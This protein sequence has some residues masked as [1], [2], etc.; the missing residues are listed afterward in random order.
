MFKCERRGRGRGK[1]TI[2]MRGGERTTEKLK[3][4][5]VIFHWRQNRRDRDACLFKGY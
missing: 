3:E 2:E 4:M 1:E 5:R